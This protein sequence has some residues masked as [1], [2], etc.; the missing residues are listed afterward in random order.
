M[1][2]ER[3]ILVGVI[4]GAHGVRG[5]VRVR[6][7]TAVPEAVAAYGPLQDETGRR[8][9]ALSVTGAAKDGVI[10]RIE[11]V[12]DRDAA[13]ALRGVRLYLPRAAL[14]PTEVEEFYHADLIGLAAEGV[15]GVPLGHV[16]A[17]QNFGAG[18]V[19]EVEPPSG[20]AALFVPFTR[21]AVPEVDIARGRLVLDPPEGLEAPARAER[22]PAPQQEGEQHDRRPAEERLQGASR[23]IARRSRGR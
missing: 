17:V 7:F 23:R 21:A 12:A 19:L 11:G 22:R 3:Q 10:A 4:A 14:P 2:A 9:F 20:E 18:D 13:Q 6:S 1:A 15:D 8:R 5:Q 16:V